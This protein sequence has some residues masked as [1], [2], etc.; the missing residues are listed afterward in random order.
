MNR[1]WNN[2]KWIYVRKLSLC[3]WNSQKHRTV[4]AF[5]CGQQ[6]QT[7][8]LLLLHQPGLNSALC[9]S[10]GFAIFSLKMVFCC[11]NWCCRWHHVGFDTVHTWSCFANPI[12]SLKQT[13][14][15]PFLSSLR[16]QRKSASMMVPKSVPI[17]KDIFAP[18]FEANGSLVEIAEAREANGKFL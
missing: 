16:L 6:P 4:S 10:F 3:T 1:L 5:H 2:I 15:G 8:P 18:A 7:N 13:L 11:R 14:V 17:V 12:F 9:T